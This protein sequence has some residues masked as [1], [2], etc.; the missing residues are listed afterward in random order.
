MK[1]IIAK[2]QEN[3]FPIL[4]VL[5]T[6]VLSF[7]NYQSGT[8][9][10]GWDT[11]H[12]EFD[13]LLNFKRAINGV[14]M[15]H[16]G[17]GA[18]ASQAHP[19]EIP[20]IIL[21]AFLSLFFPTHL[22]RY[23]YFALC[24]VFGPLG[25]YFF[26]ERIVFKNKSQF[27]K[28]VPSFLGALF[29]LLNLGTLQ[30]FYV[31]LEMFATQYASLGWLF[32]MATKFLD[33]KE[34]K[35]FCFF[36]IAAFLAAPMAHTATLFYAFALGFLIYILSYSF[37][38]PKKKSVF[39]KRASILVLSL[40]IIN[41]FW[42]LPN[43]YYALNHGHEV[44]NSKIHRLFTY[45]AIFQ[46]S[47]FANIKDASVLK[48]FLFNWGEHIGQG[49]FG[50]L[51]DEWKSHLS[52]PL[53]S[54][55]GFLFF[56]IILFGLVVSLFKRNKHGLA[57][58]PLT[59]F[60]L[61]FIIILNP[62]LEKVYLW[63]IDNIRFFQEAL[64]FPF[65]KF[66]FLLMFGYA[67]Y[68]SLGVSYLTELL[69]KIFKK[70]LI[71]LLLFA[72]L[73]TPA[74]IFYMLPTF[75]G[76]LI[77]PSMKINIPDE[78]F[79]LFDWFNQQ[80]EERIAKLP[81][82][83]FWGWVYHDWGYQGA[84]FIWF[85]LKQPLLDREFDR[86][87]SFNEQ[88]YQEMAYAIYS[89]NLP[90][91]EQ[92]LD[93][94]Q[95]RWLL[96]DE[97]VIAP[98]SEIGILFIQETKEMLYSSDKVNL[99][100][101][102][103]EKLKIYQVDLQPANEIS[104]SF[105]LVKTE[106]LTRETKQEIINQMPSK[107]D[108]HIAYEVAPKQVIPLDLKK[109]ELLPEL[110]G[111]QDVDQVFGVTQDEKINGFKLLARNGVTCVKIPLSPFLR[112]NIGAGTLLEVKF[113]HQPA[114]DEE[115]FVCLFD[116]RL[117]RCAGQDFPDY[118][119]LLENGIE[120]YQLQFALDAVGFKEEKSI[121]YKNINLVVYGQV[122]QKRIPQLI[123]GAGF[124]DITSLNRQPGFCGA[125]DPLEFK[126]EIAKENGNRYI[127]YFSKEGSLC[128]HFSYPQLAHGQGYALLI[129]S[130][131][132]EG[133]PLKICLTNYQTRRCDLYVELP[134]TKSFQKE[135]YLIP[136]MEKGGVGY[137]VNVNNYSIGR[138]TSENH[139][140]SIEIFPLKYDWLQTDE[141]KQDNLIVLD[142]AYEKNWLA[143][144]YKKPF[145]I[146]PLKAHVLVN[147]WANGWVL[148][149]EETDRIIFIFL[150][151][152]LEYFG[153]LLLLAFGCFTLV[154]LIK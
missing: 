78:Y 122:S 26:L 58:L 17:L 11:L 84:G 143:L 19:A 5:I 118:Y 144:E 10:S 80:E 72:F 148:E 100:S 85:G 1:K 15:E 89:Q 49:K 2:V 59:A 123:Q 36:S 107:L 113:D 129:E 9:L 42:L 34:K 24:L 98:G 39:L 93:K 149:N 145:S 41:S 73:I 51:L 116:N 139:L 33:S 65:T 28:S 104:Q 25:V 75:Q 79:Q 3:I 90:L 14:W 127:N 61:F 91:L 146:R 31:P 67:V 133:L 71:I 77:S 112:E 54:S 22:L 135:V 134:R 8:W 38:R 117:G 23:L 74:L 102:F 20:R 53:A 106:N 29:Y 40:L 81:I 126:R 4:L 110:C 99:V 88:A 125:S 57:L 30:Y 60:A 130:R 108:P 16:Q 37:L 69:T 114:G 48:S 76:N 111:S 7:L 140:K 101:K 27:G 128:D 96:L 132:I 56:A 103:G 153:F 137:D 43:V 151:Q 46:S 147:N 119:F 94:Y 92:V 109:V 82:H 152:L 68:F 35:Y 64:R 18:T 138:Q 70:K 13:F 131:N 86:W 55:L 124:F 12:P 142:Q 6:I 45:E 52:N 50:D 136:P 150:P 141:Q 115:P 66:S 47:Q 87:S 97:S 154:F 63:L 21:L 83:T 44:I 105:Q 62:G 32:L 120:N 121:W 95:I